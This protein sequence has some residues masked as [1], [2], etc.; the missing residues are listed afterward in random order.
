[1]KMIIIAAAI[2]T[3]SQGRCLLVRKRGTE[4]F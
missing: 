1:M 2:I 3:D 4:Y